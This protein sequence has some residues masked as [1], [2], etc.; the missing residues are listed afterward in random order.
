VQAIGDPAGYHEPSLS[1]DD[2]KVIFGRSDGGEPQDIYIQDLSRGNTTR[3]TFDPS[4]DAT[5]I[6]SPD[7]SQVLFYSARGRQNAFYLKSSSGAGSEEL[8]LTGD[9]GTYPDSWSRDGKYLVYEKNGGA[10]NKID[11]WALPM[12]GEKVPFPYIETPFEEAHAQFSPDSRWVA[13]TSNESGRSEVYVQS[14]P[15]GGGK[16][17][18]STA[19]GDQ[20]QW[21]SDG[22]EL[23]YIAPDRNLMAVSI[24]GSL[25]LAVGRPTV[26][27]Q[28]L[29]PLSGITDDRNNFAP[30]KDGQR[31]LINTLAESANTQPL[32]LV[33]NWASEMK[34]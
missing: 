13:Y 6:F 3:L 12:T 1:K 4:A 23:F 26:L 16:W 33:L 19:G 8:V 10:Q 29:M 21:R 20:P 15:V 25:T 2:T 32:I 30:S 7:E 28:T 11:L 34:R 18:I 24:E 14:F 22:K 5:S 27:F 9:G 17:Q 31:F